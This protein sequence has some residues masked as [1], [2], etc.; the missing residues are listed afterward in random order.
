MALLA[1]LLALSPSGMDFD[2]KDPKEIS[3][4]SLSLDSMLEPI[5]GYAKGIS[6]TI[7]FDPAHPERA[8]GALA[9]D[10]SSIRFA[11]DGYTETA[12]G[13]ALNEK[14]WPQILL[15]IRKVES[16]KQV[17]KGVF[18]G[19]VLA[20]LV[21]RGIAQ[22]KRLAVTASYHPGR[23]EER[24]NGRSK[25]D[26][27]I[28][29][30][31]FDISRKAHGISEGIPDDLVGDR[32]EVG[33]AVVGTHYTDPK[34]DARW[35]MEVGHRDDPTYVQVT[36]TGDRLSFRTKE[37][38]LGALVQS[39]E[40]GRLAFRLDPNPTYGEATGAFDAAGGG[41]LHAKDGDVGLR[42]RRVAAFVASPSAKPKGT[43]FESLDLGKAM[44]EA[45][46]AGM[47]VARIA[48]YRVAEIGAYGMRR[49]GGTE[50]IEP[51][52]L[53]QAGSMGHPALHLTVL[54][55]AVAGR[56]EL[57]RSANAYLGSDGLPDARVT[58]L[59][60]MRGTS[61]LPFEKFA[62]V[63]LGLPVPT[64]RASLGELKLDGNLGGKEATS[65]TN[66][67]LLELILAK[68]SG[69]PASEV[70][71]EE[72]FR[73]CGMTNSVYLPRPLQAASGHYSSGE[74]T[75]DPV[76]IYPAALE[77]G[78]WTSVDD[79]S[80][81]L[82]ELTKLFAGRSNVLLAEKDRAFLA[83]VDAPKSVLGVRKGEGGEMYL[84]GDPY[85]FFCVFFVNPT[86]GEGA[87]VM[88][89]R[90]MAWKLANSVAAAVRGSR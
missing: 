71:A 64:L 36:R 65:A 63:P 49:A 19:I 80:K 33:V 3:A 4:V 78:L 18:K 41:V 86:K 77:S 15:K 34:P 32:I 10:V 35:E 87:L 59:D 7:R 76:H 58:V 21:C 17:S 6:G 5:V 88:Q 13:Y 37:G 42:G 85:G 69:R 83:K 28:L 70:V 53:F 61:G 29:R 40:G 31:R 22:P 50:P 23:A 1:A 43:G 45:G 60:L 9:V 46:T 81:L 90:M 68:A 73:P 74:P 8:G 11:N 20:D 67:A 54:R 16:V 89:N 56:I 12:R 2:Y 75:L 44:R 72:V 82:A 79:F 27:L 38:S 55:L 52:T 57:E 51:R 47:A 48:D 62:G 66:E 25:G 84:G 26:L 39:Q 14:K 30:T 24:T